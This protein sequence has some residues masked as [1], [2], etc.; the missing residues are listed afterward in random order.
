VPLQ[1]RC[2]WD[3]GIFMY[4]FVGF[5]PTDPLEKVRVYSRILSLRWSVIPKPI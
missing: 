4:V 1:S 5:G 3:E 2:E